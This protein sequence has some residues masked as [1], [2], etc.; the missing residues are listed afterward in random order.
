MQKHSKRVAVFSAII[1]FL[2][3]LHTAKA[4][5]LL[6]R[7]VTIVDP[8]KAALIPHRDVRIRSGRIVSIESTP[9]KNTTDIVVD[10]RGRFLVPGFI[11]SHVHLNSAT[12]LKR[13]YTKDFEK[14]YAEFQRQQ[15]RSFL[16]HGFTTVIENNGDS[17][18]DAIF[19]S[20][21]QHPRLIHCAQAAVL[22]ND[23]MAAEFDSAAEFRE[24]FPNF[25][26]D[27]E[28]SGALPNDVDRA[29]HTA[30]AVVE[31]IARRGG[32]CVKLYYEGSF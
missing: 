24:A 23:F 6:I 20:A 13:Q 29:Q 4:Q 19:E 31:K 16:Y 9:V 1:F 15:P 18:I 8:D 30:A 7:N 21:P 28:S 22:L 17:A 11:D 14:L 12:G 27:R 5:T 26:H 3:L 25:L 32:R 2:S 10:G